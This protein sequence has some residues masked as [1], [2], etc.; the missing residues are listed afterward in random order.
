MC[1]GNRGRPVSQSRKEKSRGIYYLQEIS[2]SSFIGYAA[3]KI[4]WRICEG[5]HPPELLH[6]LSISGL[7]IIDER[8]QLHLSWV[9]RSQLYRGLWGLG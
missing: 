2:A 1:Q 6:L 8:L 9:R 3:G 7:L 4:V 5:L